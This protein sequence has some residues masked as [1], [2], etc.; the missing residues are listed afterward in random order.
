MVAAAAPASAI[1]GTIP[2]GGHGSPPA[3]RGSPRR[4]GADAADAAGASTARDVATG[5]ST[6]RDVADRAASSREG[7][8]LSA[9]SRSLDAPAAGAA[10]GAASADAT[11]AASA[12]GHGSPPATRGSPRRRR[13]RA[14]SWASGSPS[15]RA[16]DVDDC[17]PCSREGAV[18]SAR[19]RAVDAVGRSAGSVGAGGS[20]SVAG[21]HGSPPFTR[22]RPRRMVAAMV[23]SSGLRAPRSAAAPR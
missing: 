6:A 19:S 5:A 7:V 12:G 13:T 3:T 10:A 21:G 22:G 11:D 18:P 14:D 23:T 16:W 1:T 15:S 20:T 9:R 17:T 8:V 2:A 4:T